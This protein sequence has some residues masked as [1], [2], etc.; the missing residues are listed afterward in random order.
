M[1]Q[2]QF[3]ILIVGGGHG[4][5][6]A[7]IALRQGGY[8]G[9]IGIVTEEAERPYERP[10]LSKE[11]LLGE[12]SFDRM[13]IRKPA[14]WDERDI[15][16][17]L[18]ERV[19]AIDP[20][21]KTVATDTGSSIAFDKLIW[22][23]GGSA[24]R[25]SCA[26]A[27]LA[28]VH[29]I[30]AKADTDAILTHLPEASHVTVVGGGYIGLEAA[31]ALRK[32]GRAVTLL[33]ALDRPLARVAGPELST[34]YI[35]EH[36]QQGVDLRVSTS[37]TSL[38]GEGGRVTLVELAD[39]TMLQTD[40]VI[41]GIGISP[42]IAPLQEA[43][44]VCE[45]GVRVD[46][47]CRTS[48]PDI[49]AIGDCALH[50]NRFA[51]GREVRIESVQNAN[52]Q[53]NAAAKVILGEDARYDAV[54]WFWSN[55]YDLKLQTVGLSSGFDDTVLRGDPAD[56]SFSVVYLRSGRIIALDCVNRAKDYVQGRRLVLEGAAPDK[57][58]L[59]DDTIPLKALIGG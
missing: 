53:A 41:V 12:K 30:R 35:E 52:D 1:P 50:E 36:R 26:G 13:M 8:A 19:T 58:A 37:V 31:A 54:P 49:F 20:A 34:F 42:E 47:Q 24:R 18:G 56:R 7:A 39:G 5:A 48:L 17:R 59:A 3:D 55:Q 21:A 57:S 29:V 27:D 6:Q 2:N 16:F 22:A 43:G 44:A 46:A 40:M 33:E 38:H 9:A 25:L 10:P 11:Y 23:A 28:G 4:G 32:L 51:A 14:F 45:N 15:T